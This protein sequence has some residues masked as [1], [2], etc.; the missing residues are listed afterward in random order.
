MA[1]PDVSLAEPALSP[2]GRFRARGVVAWSS[3]VF[4]VLQSICGAAVL[5]N[6]F[7]LMIGIG[8]LTFTSGIGLWMA[9]FH[10]DWIRVPMILLAFLGSVA[11]IALLIRLR[12]LRNRP[13]AQW[14]RRPLTRAQVRSE[15]MQWSVSIA[16]LILIGIEEY[17]HLGFHGTL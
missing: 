5:L 3:L 10:E 1:T 14:R 8:A 7:R 17:L 4:A 13:A 2:G 16:A 6:G 9:E 12:R 15:V 11:N